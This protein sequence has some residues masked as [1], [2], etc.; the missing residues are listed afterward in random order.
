MDLIERFAA[1][2]YE[3]HAC[4]EGW[5]LLIDPSAVFGSAAAPRIGSNA[6]RSSAASP[7]RT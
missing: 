5:E 6:A 3:L 1:C 2:G 7:S 4:D